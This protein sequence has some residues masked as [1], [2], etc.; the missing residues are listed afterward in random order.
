MNSV[1]HAVIA[2]TAEASHT[3]LPAPVWVFA[4]VP[5]V[6]FAGLLLVTFAFS[7]VGKRD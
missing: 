2:G 1:A 4:V 7:G 3:A 5:L 6:V